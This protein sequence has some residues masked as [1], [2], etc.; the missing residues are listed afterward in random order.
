MRKILLALAA[1]FILV[2]IVLPTEIQA[3]P[4]SPFVIDVT[5]GATQFQMLGQNFLV[6]CTQPLRIMFHGISDAR[7]HGMILST[8]GED[9]A[10]IKFIWLDF[11]N[12]PLT[13]AE[14]VLANQVYQFD[15]D[16]VTGHN[17]KI[18]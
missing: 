5:P 18:W 3:A 2:G 11:H 17:E 8:N 16:E 4:S 15:S 6:I 13:L 7:V 10:Q 14:G 12:S 1:A 9:L